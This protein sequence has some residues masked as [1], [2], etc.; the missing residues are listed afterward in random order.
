MFELKR[1]FTLTYHNHINLLELL[2]LSRILRLTEITDLQHQFLYQQKIERLQVMVNQ[3]QTVQ[4]SHI[5]HQLLSEIAD[6]MFLKS[7]S[8]L[9]QC[10]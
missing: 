5:G 1:T 7:S 3:A 10:V 4:M 2:V 8:G 9:K 6:F